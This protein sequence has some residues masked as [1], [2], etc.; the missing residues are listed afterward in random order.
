MVFRPSVDTDMGLGEQQ[1]AGYA[2]CAAEC[3]KMF[4][5]YGRFC[6][7]CGSYQSGFQ[8]GFIF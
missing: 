8:T 7:L 4:S 3:V 6:S 2:A 5:Q 1:N